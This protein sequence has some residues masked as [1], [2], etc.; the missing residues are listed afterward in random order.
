MVQQRDFNAEVKKIQ[1]DVK[2][3]GSQRDRLNRDAGV[4]ENRR[5]EALRKLVELGIE[6]AKSMTAADLE[7]LENTTRAQLEQELKNLTAKVAEGKA[8]M[9]E[10][11][12]A[13]A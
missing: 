4:E 11:A 12:E 10:H 9:A 2:A 3:L 8:L 13:S 1:E 5:D 7:V 6:N